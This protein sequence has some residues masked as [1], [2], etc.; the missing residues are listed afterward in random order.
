MSVYVCPSFPSELPIQFVQLFHYPLSL[1]HSQTCFLFPHSHISF[2]RMKLLAFS[3]L[4]VLAFAAPR[5]KRQLSI[6]TISVSGAGGSTGCVVTGNV[7]YANG[8]RLRNLTSSEQSE[9]ATYQTEVEQY[10]TVSLYQTFIVHG[11]LSSNSVT[12]STNAVRTFAADSCPTAAASSRCNR[13]T[14]SAASPEMTTLF[15]RPRKSRLS[16]LLRRP[17]STIST[18]AWFR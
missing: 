17:P 9:L 6:G 14:T 2:S 10:K 7:L 4:C 18:D 3:A 8:I 12:F 1:I 16:V 15:R 13:A 5:E 11:I